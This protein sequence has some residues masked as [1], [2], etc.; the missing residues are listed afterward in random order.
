M[1]VFLLV[2]VL[3]ILCGPARSQ[4]IAS[5]PEGMIRQVIETG[6]MDGHVNKQLCWMGDAAAVH[7][8]K[9]IG[10]RNLTGQE[11]SSVL[12][13]LWIAFAA[14]KLVENP[15]DREPRATLFVLRYLALDTT[16]PGLKRRIE[17]ERNHM[18]GLAPFGA[19]STH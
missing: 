10:G 17:E 11:A 1:R 12:D 4:D 19:G 3:P 5:D 14:P 15:S 13:I 6:R 8:V 2:L 7:I 18:E 9:I 16:D